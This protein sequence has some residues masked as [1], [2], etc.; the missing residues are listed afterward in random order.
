VDYSRLSDKALKA[1]LDAL[2]KEQ[3]T[4][5]SP[6]EIQKA[7]KNEA[8]LKKVRAELKERGL[9]YGAKSKK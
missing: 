2:V 5:K 3:L 9:I 7:K 4:P 8:E 1:R 6:A